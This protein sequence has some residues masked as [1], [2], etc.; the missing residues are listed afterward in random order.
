MNPD[1][2]LGS[3]AANGVVPP[4]GTLA[5]GIL[6]GSRVEGQSCTDLKGPRTGIL[7][8]AG[9]RGN[10]P[11]VVEIADD[12]DGQPSFLHAGTVKLSAV[13]APSPAGSVPLPTPTPT[14]DR[15]ALRDRI[16]EALLNGDMSG[17]DV[18]DSEAKF[19][20]RVADIA[21][22]PVVD[23]LR[24][25][26]ARL[27][28]VA[29]SALE[30]R[31]AAR[32]ELDTAREKI[33]HLDLIMGEVREL[34]EVD[35]KATDELVVHTLQERLSDACKKLLALDHPERPP[36]TPVRP[37]DPWDPQGSEAMESLAQEVAAAI[38]QGQHVKVTLP[39]RSGKTAFWARVEE[40][41]SAPVSPAVP[42]DPATP[43]PTNDAL[44]IQL[45]DA[46]AGMQPVGL[47]DAKALLKMIRNGGT[48][49]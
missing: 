44:A 31:S 28:G 27:F 17:M 37:V 16:A 23:E 32:R 6:P 45:R 21:V 1:D 2:I 14:E 38:G 25:E 34:A 11:S 35:D 42:E 15:E 29:A 33:H 9:T 47:V 22:M 24:G 41:T 5:D 30:E 48:T 26:H 36:W 49:S 4:W 13:P 43:T 39:R 20:K 7:V 12:H 10:S 3:A 8:G 46:I 18:P 40:L 19:W